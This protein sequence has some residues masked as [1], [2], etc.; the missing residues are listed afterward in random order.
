MAPY[1]ETGP[2]D[3][4]G[5]MACDTM[6]HRDSN[7]SLF[8]CR[9]TL[10]AAPCHVA[11]KRLW[12]QLEHAYEQA[13][14]TYQEVASHLDSAGLSELMALAGEAD[15]PYP[16]HP[17]CPLVKPK[18]TYRRQQFSGAMRTGLKAQRRGDVVVAR[19]WYQQALICNPHEPGLPSLVYM[20]DVRLRMR[21]EG[22]QR[23]RDIQHK[24]PGKLN[25]IQSS[26]IISRHGRNCDG[27]VSKC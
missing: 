2:I 16:G 10:D 9:E 24:S 26:A 17:L 6:P 7:R 11:A 22:C 18:S 1:T 8:L 13:E 27:T 19:H 21:G 5:K 20:M 23:L 12:T 15:R 14:R 25:N 4:L 3:Q